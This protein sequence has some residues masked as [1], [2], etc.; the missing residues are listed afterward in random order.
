MIE[1]KNRA[2]IKVMGNSGTRLATCYR[3]FGGIHRNSLRNTNKCFS[4]QWDTYEGSASIGY[5]AIAVNN[6]GFEARF[7]TRRIYKAVKCKTASED[8]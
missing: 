7:A 6:E 1:D 4:R 8:E 3:S 2:V 5:G